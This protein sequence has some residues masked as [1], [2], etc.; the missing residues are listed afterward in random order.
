MY[1]L[2]F[3]NSC[4][5]ELRVMWAEQTIRE[6]ETEESLARWG[7]VRPTGRSPTLKGLQPKR[8]LELPAEEIQHHGGVKC[9][10]P[11]SICLSEFVEGDEVRR[12]PGCKHC[13]HKSCVDLWLLQQAHCPLCKGK[14]E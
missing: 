7:H 11:C 3:V 4:L 2:C 8:I 9:D 13:F 1:L 6:V 14:V 5:D 10:E 12:L